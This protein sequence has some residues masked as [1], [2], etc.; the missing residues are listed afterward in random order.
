MVGVCEFCQEANGWCVYEL[1]A[2][3]MVCVCELV[4]VLSGG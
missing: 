1:I 4:A 3:L 2:V